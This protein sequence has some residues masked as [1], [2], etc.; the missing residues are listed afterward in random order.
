MAGRA[1]AAGRGG[2]GAEPWLVSRSSGERVRDLYCVACWE[3][4][5]AVAAGAVAAV[6]G[7]HEALRGKKRG[8]GDRAA[9]ADPLFF[10]WDH[11]IPLSCPV[12]EGLL[13]GA[14]A[15]GAVVPRDA[16]KF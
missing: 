12:S 5:A 11:E 15:V 14:G 4:A 16:R 3:A 13:D 1:R 9:T 7:N 6:R 10:S 2:A 8:Y